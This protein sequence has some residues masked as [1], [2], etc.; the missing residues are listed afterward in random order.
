MPYVARDPSGKII[1]V[2]A[3]V[4]PLATEP[5]AADAAELA[6]F[7]AEIAPGS[8]E[9]GDLAR[10]DLALIRVVEDLVDTLIDKNLILFTD[11]PSAAREKLMERRSLRRS[12]NKLNLLGDAGEDSGTLEIRL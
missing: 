12:H 1:A 9:N 3:A 7:L 4:S 2:S 11:L 5:I 6:V 10:S 8:T